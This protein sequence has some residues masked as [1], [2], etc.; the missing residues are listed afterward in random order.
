MLG[1]IIP[2]LA[3]Q[4][5]I[6]GAPLLLSGAPAA[7]QPDAE[8]PPP[9]DTHDAAPV[10]VW[11]HEITRFR[12]PVAGLS[13]AQRAEQTE[14]RILALPSGLREY[15]VEARPAALGP[16][17]GVVVLVNSRLAFGMLE[18]DLDPVADE[19]LA[20]AAAA[21]AARLE[22]WLTRRDEQKHWPAV[23]RGALWSVVA[24]LLAVLFWIQLARV[25]GRLLRRLEEAT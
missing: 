11:N 5:A 1:R 10:I 13:P 15:R 2:A 6:C 3:L 25:A 19:T 8:S 18:T 12:A 17:S 20:S 24:T 14:R 9:A 21:A 23:L 4:V 22:D 7:A 16:D